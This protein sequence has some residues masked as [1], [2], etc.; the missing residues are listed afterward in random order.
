MFGLCD[1]WSATRRAVCGR[2]GS[3][4]D[5]LEQSEIVAFIRVFVGHLN[6]IDDSEWKSKEGLLQGCGALL[7]RVISFSFC[8]GNDFEA[9]CS[10][11][12]DECFRALRNSQLALRQ[13]AVSLLSLL[14]S[15]Q[16]PAVV[17]LCS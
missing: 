14:L 10:R 1:V 15:K 6:A 2:I 12:A 11:L 3:L 17:P 5:V 7:S 4:G 13:Q 9:L 16:S 8:D